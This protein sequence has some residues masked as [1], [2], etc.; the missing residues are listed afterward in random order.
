MTLPA[1]ECV[2]GQEEVKLKVKLCFQHYIMRQLLLVSFKNR[3]D[4]KKNRF[5]LLA[6]GE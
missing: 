2:G 4:R 3:V 5:V 6:G 1:I